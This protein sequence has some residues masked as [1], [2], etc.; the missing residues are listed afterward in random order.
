MTRINLLPVALFLLILVAKSRSCELDQMRSGCR[1]N[2]GQCNC[3][4]G[5]KSEYRYETVEECRLALRGVRHDIC[6]RKPCLHGGSCLQITQD[7]GYKCLCEGTG[8]YGI[9]CDKSCP[10]P[11]NLRF[12]GP[13]PYECVVI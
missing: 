7:P 10:G 3:G 12:R 1:I 11:N 6:H 8:F 5:C 13:F 2:S 4:Y 9:R